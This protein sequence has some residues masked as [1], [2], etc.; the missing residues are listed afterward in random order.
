MR[1]EGGERWGRGVVEGWG[2]G[3]WVERGGRG[4]GEAGG[5]DG[6]G[7]RGWG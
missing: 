3:E 5:G 6:G 1:C 4:G 2:G 7:W